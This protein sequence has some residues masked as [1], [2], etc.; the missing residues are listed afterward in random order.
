MMELGEN[1][2]CWQINSA[3]KDE[4]WGKHPNVGDLPHL[5]R[6]SP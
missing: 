6:T 2:E 3:G 1:Q 5:M 4:Q